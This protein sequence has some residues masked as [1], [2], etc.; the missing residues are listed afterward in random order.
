M[1]PI[2]DEIIERSRRGERD[3]FRHLVEQHQSYA[4]AL[5]FRLVCDEDA[6]KDVV[7][8]S[9]I[10]VWKHLAEY[11]PTVKFTTWLYRIVV[12]LAYDKLKTDR[13]R[14]RVM[15]SERNC[16]EVQGPS[17]REASETA[18]MN[19]DLAERIRALA[20]G[21]PPK[22]RL[23]FTLRDLQDLSVQETADI[24]AISTNTVKVNLSYARQWI[25]KNLDG[26]GR[27]ER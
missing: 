23:V 3:A 21:L 7:Q 4:F 12:N 13:R 25:R 24:L 1:Q 16:E 20:L 15:S 22:Q 6:A 17:D 18:I 10:R 2:P 14:E 9:F 11:R 26:S 8:E 27:R 19:R 5:A